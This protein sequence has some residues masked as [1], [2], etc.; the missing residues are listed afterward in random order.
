MSEQSNK[1][2][3]RNVVYLGILN[4]SINPVVRLI[5]DKELLNSIISAAISDVAEHDRILADKDQGTAIT[6]SGPPEQALFVAMT[7]RD[8]IVNHNKGSEEHLMVRTGISVGPVK[9][10]N[11]N[12]VPY[13]QGEGVDVAERVMSLAKPNQILASRAYFEI[14]SE[15]TDEIAG[16]FSPFRHGRGEHEVYSVRSSEEEPFVPEFVAESTAESPLFSRLFNSENPPRYGLWG[17]AALAAAAVLAAS[18]MLFS[19][20]LHPDLGVVMAHSESAAP[21]VSTGAVSAPSAPAEYAPP[22]VVH[23]VSPDLVAPLGA[24]PAVTET[25]VAQPAV[26]EAAAPPSE[27]EPV[28]TRDRATRPRV[29]KSVSARAVATAATLPQPADNQSVNA[30]AAE[31]AEPGGYVPEPRQEEKKVAVAASGPVVEER[32]VPSSGRTR[33]KTIFDEFAKSFKQGRKERVCTQAERALN[34]CK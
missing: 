12:G 16:M 7:I 13:I 27:T 32:P 1:V 22:P 33:P 25:V 8:A 29:K 2:A 14:T 34:Q 26:T 11:I 10:G 17:L 4:H 5:K 18:F 15:L 21:V 28:G 6:L 9:V 20:M 3:I 19:N 31:K 24:G 30:S 23:E